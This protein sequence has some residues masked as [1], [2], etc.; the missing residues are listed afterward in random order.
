MARARILIT[1]ISVRATHSGPDETVKKISTNAR[2]PLHVE[3]GGPVLI[4]REVIRV[5]APMVGQE[6]I[7]KTILTN[8]SRRV[9]VLRILYV[10]THWALTSVWTVLGTRAITTHNVLIQLL[11]HVVTVPRRRGQDNNATGKT[12]V[13]K[14]AQP[15]R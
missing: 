9:P 4:T 12:S 10:A 1:R 6:D 11:V 3:T 13:A 14:L 5:D 2:C 15:L 8:V 7:V